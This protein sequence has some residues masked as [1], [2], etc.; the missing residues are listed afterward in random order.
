[1]QSLTIVQLFISS[2]GDCAA[3][4]KA[5]S[6][7]IA[8]ENR[9]WRAKHQIEVSAFGPD[10]LYPGAANYGQEVVNRQLQDFDIYVG[11]WREKIGTQTPAAPSG[12]VEELR[13]AFLR[14]RRTRRPWILCYFWRPSPT[15]FSAVKNEIT[16]NGG[17]YQNFDNP[18]HLAKQL[19][20]HLTRYLERDF[21]KPGHSTTRV[22][23]PMAVA[24]GSPPTMFFHVAEI[25]EGKPRPVSFDRPV[26]AVGRMRELN[27]IVL[28]N[29]RVHREQ[30]IFAWEDGDVFYI[31]LAGDSRVE[32]RIQDSRTTLHGHPV[33][34][35]GDAVVMPDGSRIVLRAVVDPLPR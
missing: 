14:Y 1:M 13:N 21:L 17:F 28:T 9:F 22:T 30:G 7:A 15:D 3:E 35:I 8:T 10:D 24:S 5:T 20:E 32:R 16:S 33:L 23:G 25:E 2:P 31:D 4:R 11:I 34:K 26:V 27:Q 29:N 6:A 19:C 12:T 18:Q